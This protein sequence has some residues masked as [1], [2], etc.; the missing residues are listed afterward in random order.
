[1][2]CLL[3]RTAAQALGTD[4]IT[5]LLNAAQDAPAPAP[6]L[7]GISGALSGASALVNQT[8]SGVRQNL[9][10]A[11]AGLNLTVSQVTVAP[12]CYLR[13]HSRS[14]HSHLHGQSLCNIN[15][16][17]GYCMPEYSAWLRLD[18]YIS[19]ESSVER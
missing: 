16:A 14:V 15:M 19:D 6:A 7:T 11:A 18:I 12:L 2:S 9:Q 17:E 4:P 3:C 1:M 10:S 5:L 13:C 8:V